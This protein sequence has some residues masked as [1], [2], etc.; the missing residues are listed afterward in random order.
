MT[1]RGTFGPVVLLGLGTG[2][3]CAVA[4]TK[5]WVV[6]D[7]ARE[8]NPAGSTLW[9]SWV[10]DAPLAGALAL[11]LLACWGVVLVTRGRARRLVALLALVAAIGLM[12]TTIW[13]GVQGPDLLREN[14]SDPGA[15][16]VLGDRSADPSYTG[17]FWTAVVASPLAVIAS[18]LGVRLA[19]Q[20]PEMGSRYDAP[21][22][23][24]GAGS[25][26]PE[27]NLDIWKAIDEG[28][29]PTA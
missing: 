11:V 17:W 29:D 5:D 10:V 23:A 3:L 4:G 18:A 12:V 9:D 14:L 25:A 15:Q 28:E 27:D 22:S 24:P 1:P 21:S 13:T 19:P 6:P 8:S 16:A 26:V 2:A 20:W 7:L